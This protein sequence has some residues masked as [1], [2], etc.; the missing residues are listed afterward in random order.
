M[1]MAEKT[2][3]VICAGCGEEIPSEDVY[4]SSKGYIRKQCKKCNAALHRRYWLLKQGRDPNEVRGTRK[5][6]PITADARSL[7]RVN[8]LHDLENDRR[9]E[10]DL[11]LRRRGT[12]QRLA[13]FPPAG[14]LRSMIMVETYVREALKE[15]NDSAV[16]TS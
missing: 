13:A 2:E 12:R 7:A 16:C 14:K 8:T 3:A 6:K 1:K 10:L 5:K 4:V 11:T 9:E 15:A